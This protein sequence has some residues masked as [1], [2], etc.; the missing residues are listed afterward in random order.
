VTSEGST[1]SALLDGEVRETDLLE[2]TLAAA[3][4]TGGDVRLDLRPFQVLT[5]RI[6]R[7]V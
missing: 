7:A 1:P 6:A 5:L 4:V 2:R 3:D